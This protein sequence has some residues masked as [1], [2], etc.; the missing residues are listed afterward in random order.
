ML[1][2]AFLCSLLLIFSYQAKSQEDPDTSAL[3]RDLKKSRP[4]TGRVQLLLNMSRVYFDNSSNSLTRV[5]TAG[6]YARQA[7]KLSRGIN[8]RA[9]LATAL[10]LQSNVYR[11]RGEAR[12]AQ[13][14]LDSGITIIKKM[15]DPVALA[16][17][18]MDVW[19]R[20]VQDA[21]GYRQQMK[22]FMMA[23]D[24][25]KHRTEKLPKANALYKVGNLY[26]YAGESK[27]ALNYFKEAL[28]IYQLVHYPQA[29]LAYEQI[30][31]IYVE[32]GDVQT[33]LK[34]DLKAAEIVEKLKLNTLIV[35]IIYNAIGIMFS[36]QNIPDKAIY[37]FHKALVVAEANHNEDHIR[38]LHTNIAS[39]ELRTGQTRKALK[40]LQIFKRYPPTDVNMKVKSANM[41]IE[42]YLRL[43]DFDRAKPYYRQ[44][45]SID[46][47]T[48][49]SPDIKEL[50]LRGTIN[51]L[52]STGQF[53]ATLPLLKGYETYW[54]KS[55][56]LLKESQG[57]YLKFRTD[58]GMGNF[59]TAI[60]HHIRFKSLSD[61]ALDKEKS[62]QF[63]QLSLKFETEKKDRELITKEQRIAL[64]DKQSQLQQSV[65]LQE[66]QTKNEV[67]AGLLVLTALFG[68]GYSRYR[69][70]QRTNRKL[71]LQQAEIHGKNTALQ[72]LLSEKEWLLK[73]IHHRVKNNLQIVISLLNTQSA[74][75]DSP[76]AMDAIRNSQ[77]RMQAISLIHQKLYQSENL[78]TI[79]M[80]VYIRELVEYLGES[81]IYE[82]KIKMKLNISPMKLDVAQA[83]P[84]GLILNEA[85]SNSI[86]YA[87]KKMTNGII[88]I[89]LTL[90]DEERYSLSIADNGIGLPAGFDLSNTNSLGM[91]LMHGLSDQLEADLFLE[92]DIGLRVSIIF[93][94]LLLK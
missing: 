45:V 18:Y 93:K 13:L 8:Y 75:L 29:Y 74:Y 65:L 92:N 31:W 54:K 5:D 60:Q 77:N 71:E 84:L 53:N 21:A 17:G 11:K 37:Y 26:R 47:S 43:K 1:K 86:K 83:V 34:Y 56:N 2:N 22:Y 66:R 7:L 32:L 82:N 23:L 42:A 4:D 88:T 69:L 12:L 73:E 40:S 67:F 3:K 44:L 52:Q 50:I 61:S 16:N 38:N 39:V 58:S 48:V 36:R 94:P 30:G 24:L 59:L 33:G 41:F 87:F 80:G 25:L 85:I 6:S 10:L 81:F 49:A 9:G 79:D 55:G 90:V 70:K 14:Y 19:F 57:E 35:S 76:E 46:T 72:V 78:K 15:H 68:L 91:R 28:A 63:S 62:R 27:T 89:T 64:L 20:Y 51:Y